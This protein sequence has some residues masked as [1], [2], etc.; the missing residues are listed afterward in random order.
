[1]VHTQKLKHR[2]SLCIPVFN[3]ETFKRLTMK[4]ILVT[5]L[6]HSK[7]PCY[8]ILLRQVSL[9]TYTTLNFIVITLCVNISNLHS[10]FGIKTLLSRARTDNDARLLKL[11]C[12]L[13]RRMF[14]YRLDQVNVIDGLSEIR[15]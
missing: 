11:P 13:H 5:H 1:L 10:V 12:I 7:S 2:Y 4:V 8:R 6:S 14:V 9:F 15:L 3:N